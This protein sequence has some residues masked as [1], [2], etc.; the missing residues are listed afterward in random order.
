MQNNKQKV[1][2]LPKD[3]NPNEKSFSSKRKV[4]YQEILYIT[5]FSMPPEQMIQEFTVIQK[6][7][8][9]KMIITPF[10]IISEDLKEVKKLTD[11]LIKSV[12][13]N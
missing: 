2:N 1:F 11:M 13:Y 3:F 12:Q 5:I 10:G 7:D 6:R 4:T 8:K 9:L